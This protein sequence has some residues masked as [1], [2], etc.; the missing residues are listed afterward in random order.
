MSGLGGA[1][2][3]I[4]HQAASGRTITVDGCV[5]VPQ[6]AHEAMFELLDPSLKGAGVY[7]WRATKDNAAE[8]GY[9]SAVVP[10][11]VAAYSKLHEM[12]GSMPLE[13]VM[14]PAIQLAAEGFVPNWYVFAQCAASM[15]RLSQFPETMSVFFRADGTQLCCMNR[16]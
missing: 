4:A 6:N 1:A 13:Q 10:G 15:E 3:I 7:G 14:A 16:L 8:T 11:A 2:Y 12:Q 5:E 9:R